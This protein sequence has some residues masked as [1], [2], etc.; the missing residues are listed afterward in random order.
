M[1]RRPG[2]NDPCP[3]GSGRKYKKCCYLRESH[4]QLGKKKLVFDFQ[5][6]Q[7]Q[8]VLEQHADL[9]A[10]FG[11]YARE[12]YNSFRSSLTGHAWTGKPAANILLEFHELVEK[13]I[14]AVGR[15]HSFLF[16]LNA[17]RRL[18]RERFGLAG[19]LALTVHNVRKTC[20]VA[21][22]KYSD[23]D[24][25]DWH[26]AR[27]VGIDKPE[28]IS[29]LSYQFRRDEARDVVRLIGLAA[30]SYGLGRLLRRLNKGAKLFAVAEQFE[31]RF[32][33]DRNE[34]LV[35]LFDLRTVRY[36]SFFGNLGILA[37]EGLRSI[38]DR[39]DLLDS[40]ARGDNL[41]LDPTQYLPAVVPVTPSDVPESARH[42]CYGD[43]TYLLGVNNFLRIV[44][45]TPG[46]LDAFK[47]T[48]HV[49]EA[50]LRRN[51]G[52]TPE[53]ILFCV[54][55][56]DFAQTGVLRTEPS[57]WQQ[58]RAAGFCSYSRE[59]LFT[60]WR[61]V[62]TH[63]EFVRQF[64][65]AAIERVRGDRGELVEK[66]YE[67]FVFRPAMAEALSVFEMQKPSF[68]VELSKD[69][70]I[71]D[72]TQL[73]SVLVDATRFVIDERVS[74][75]E[76]SKK[77]ERDVSAYL[78]SRAGVKRFAFPTGYKCED[79]H[80]V[81][82]ELDVS[83]V[84]NDCLIL[85]E[86]KTA[87][88]SRE[89]ER[90][91]FSTVRN[92][93]ERI[94]SGPD[95]WLEQVEGAARQ[96][97]RRKVWGNGRV[98][99]D[100]KWVLPV[101]CSS[102]VE[103]VAEASRRYFLTEQIP[104]ICTPAE[105]GEF[106]IGWDWA[107]V[108]R[109][110]FLIRVRDS[111]RRPVVTATEKNPTGK[112]IVHQVEERETPAANP[113]TADEWAMEG[114][115]L[116]GGDMTAALACFEAAL[117]LERKHAAALSGKAIV[118]R[119]RGRPREALDILDKALRWHPQRVDL[120]VTKGALL[121]DDMQDYDAALGCYDRA[122]EIAPDDALAWTNKGIA[123]NHLGEY[124]A[125]VECLEEAYRLDPTQAHIGATLAL[126]RCDEFIE[127]GEQG[128]ALEACD[129]ALALDPL[130]LGAWSRR[131]ELL[132]RLER[133]VDAV[134][135]LQRALELGAAD[136]R[137]WNLKAAAHAALVQTSEAL[138]CVDK[139]LELEPNY[140][141]L[142]RNKDELLRGIGKETEAEECRV[143]AEGLEKEGYPK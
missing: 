139:A 68:I 12:V 44:L 63:P 8:R 14:A 75:H 133:F 81:F 103:Y 91:D 65:A 80:G 54:W 77:F 31:A 124:P 122:L 89:E 94:A 39:R 143:R 5:T 16:W 42:R 2:R 113:S 121:A 98:P 106:L 111:Q 140:P 128:A 120:L 21:A 45:E 86:C 28:K 17:L 32:D 141:D 137:T 102:K 37:D 6:L 49:H 112:T 60:M 48:K 130:R 34:K 25:C 92:R 95:S 125:A 66:F 4:P 38:T 59:A 78:S 93:W 67:N 36:S 55:M 74:D 73:G 76:R 107:K 97:A 50:F 131:S 118:L 108:R 96:L 29:G 69:F 9:D 142:W 13:E 1:G 109:S 24:I 115:L 101:V 70:V 117:R 114:A 51:R 46:L 20:E 127:R 79:E 123:L 99:D 129:Q 119:R 33:D 7:M 72:F 61:E 110:P 22:L 30:L 71:V 40:W 84:V 57:V 87:R 19:D 126:A 52:L 43:E 26:E 90:G 136:V 53:E 11:Q 100:I 85:V 62:A 58:L 104:R 15:T 134:P 116:L 47:L 64:P 10:G 105:L 56:A 88:W 18:P 82:A 138:V 3:C 35:L 83:P 132:V 23:H 135:C 41:E 27:G